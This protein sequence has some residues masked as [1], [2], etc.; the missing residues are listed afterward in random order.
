MV[1]AGEMTKQCRKPGHTSIII[2]ASIDP[3][4]TQ[5]LPQSSGTQTRTQTGLHTSPQALRLIFA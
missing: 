2:E 1:H 3:I 5:W 4:R